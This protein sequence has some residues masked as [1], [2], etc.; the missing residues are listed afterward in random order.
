MFFLELNCK[1]ILYKND[2]VCIIVIRQQ[3]KIQPL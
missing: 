3:N 2:I 1:K